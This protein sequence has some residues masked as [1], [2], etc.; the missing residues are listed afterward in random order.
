LSAKQSKRQPYLPHLKNAYQDFTFT[1]SQ[2]ANAQA[3]LDMCS[4]NTETNPD[5]SKVI[6]AFV[7][8]F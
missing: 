4:G 3:M 6:V 5:V 7:S 2:L 1:T 8:H